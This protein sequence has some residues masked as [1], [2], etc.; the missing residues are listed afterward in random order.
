[1]LS[2]YNH[3]LVFLSS[4]EHSDSRYAHGWALIYTLISV[5][6]LPSQGSSP[7]SYSFPGS[8]TNHAF[9]TL[10]YFFHFFVENIFFLQ[11]ILLIMICP[12]SS[13]LR[14]F[15]LPRPLNSKPF[16]IS[17]QVKSENIIYKQKT[18]SVKNAQSKQ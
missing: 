3:A 10:F 18:C 14:Y 4:L 1:M 8:Y 12:P 9:F 7:G 17:S 16:L 13:P 2:A 5:E 15:Q 11:Y 6:M